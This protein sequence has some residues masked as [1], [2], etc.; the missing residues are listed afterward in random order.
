MERRLRPPILI[1]IDE[2]QAKFKSKLDM[3][4]VM[5]VDSKYIAIILSS[6]LFP[7]PIDKCPVA[8]LKAIVSGEKKVFLD[9]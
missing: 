9:F 1:D 8:F 6:G 7:S 2:V 4:T 5:S 3:Y